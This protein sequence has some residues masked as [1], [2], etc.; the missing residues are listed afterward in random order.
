M[1]PG[2]W[3]AA[4]RTLAELEPLGIQLAE[5][6]VATM[7]EA[8]ELAG[9]TSIPLAG[10][11]SVETVADAARAAAANACQLTGIKLSK[12]GGL[13][14]AM[15]VAEMLPAYVS[16]AL[17][18]PVGIALRGTA[19]GSGPGHALA[20]ERRRAHG[21]ATQRLFASTIASVECELEGG[22]LRPPPGPGSGSRSTRMR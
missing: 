18:G 6:P 10:D 12:V 13:A 8:A 17:D 15:Q 9:E 22:M 19:R 1:R 2:T 14:P 5:Q 16:S 20:R 7:E 11:E 3:R 4:K 21:L